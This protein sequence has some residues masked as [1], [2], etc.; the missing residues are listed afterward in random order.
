[1]EWGSGE[2]LNYSG[3]KHCGDKLFYQIRQSM[4]SYLEYG[5]FSADYFLDWEVEF[6]LMVLHFGGT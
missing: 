2:L 3:M 5:C 4:L 1:M 6:R